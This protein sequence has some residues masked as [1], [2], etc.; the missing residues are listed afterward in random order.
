M[1]KHFEAMISVGARLDD[2]EVPFRR[3]GNGRR[4]AQLV[5]RK[6]QSLETRSSTN[7]IKAVN[8]VIEFVDDHQIVIRML[9]LSLTSFLGFVFRR[10]IFFV[11]LF[12][13]LFFILFGYEA[14]AADGEG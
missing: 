8:D 1:T 3:R 2:S 10:V 7:R 12:C 11:F 13:Y 14:E 6:Q 9:E 5:R 4:R